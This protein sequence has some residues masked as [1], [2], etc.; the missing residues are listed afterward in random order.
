MKLPIWH[1]IVFVLF[2]SSLDAIG[3]SIW[4][5]HLAGIYSSGSLIMC[6]CCCCYGEEKSVNLIMLTLPI[7]IDA[8]PFHN[9]FGKLF[10]YLSIYNSNHFCYRQQFYENFFFIKITL[11]A[12]IYVYTLYTQSY[13]STSSMKSQ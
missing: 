5:T 3:K 6:C 2:S 10:R 8:T 12:L 9:T 7:W 11:N 4:A 1:P 13:Q